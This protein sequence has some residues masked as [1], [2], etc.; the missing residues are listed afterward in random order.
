MAEAAR[1]GGGARDARGSGGDLGFSALAFVLALAPRLYVAIAWAR[2][3]VW[4][5]HY[6]DFGARRIAAGLGYSDDLLVGGQPVWHPW[7]H[8]PVGYSGFLG[9]VYKLFG[10][11]PH[12]ATVA[13]AVAGALLVVVVHRLARYATTPTRA[14]VA[15]LL[16]ALSPGLIVYAALLMTEPLAALGLVTAP[17]LLAR[18]AARGR[19]ARGAVLAGVALGLT[20]LVRP[21]SLLCAPALAL[22]AWRGPA[23]AAGGVTAGAAGGW[24]AAWRRGALAVALSSAA[25]LAVVAPWTIRNCRVMDGCALISTNGG[26]NLAI[27]SFPRATGRFETLRAGDGCPIARGQVAQDR[28]WMA[29]GSRWIQQ[30]PVRWLA[31]MPKKLS[32]TFDHESFPIGYLG[33]ANPAAWPEERRAAG[34]RVLT[35][36]HLGL[37]SVAALGVVALPRLRPR[38]ALVAQAAAIAAVLGLIAWGVLGDDHTFWPL[39][40]AI[41]LL[42]ALP[43]PGRPANGGVVG[44]LAFAVATVVL[45]HAV[46]FGEDRYHMVVTPALCILA[47]CALRRGQAARPDGHA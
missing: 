16:A 27:G 21:Q 41:P 36:S 32:F 20:A 3:P 44:Y 19:V 17:W 46:F 22:L 47:A 34:R 45:T 25:A 2:E 9:L 43:L 11:G 6:Y 33:E 42:A 29:A 8:Y 12:V 10:A 15:A 13:N 31:L 39:A 23:G 18:D 40:V 30:D 28:C 14:R 4:D 7:C 1:A 35:T 37:L 24:R 26:W 38:R 5:G